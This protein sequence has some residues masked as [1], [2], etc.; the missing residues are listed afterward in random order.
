[1][2]I[3]PFTKHSLGNSNETLPA[4]ARMRSEVERLFDR[5]LQSP[6]AE[7]N[8][9]LSSSFAW[10]P[11]VDIAENDAELTIRAE[12]PGIDPGDVNVSISDNLLTISGEKREE[13]EEK[14]E[15][16]YHCERRF[17]SFTRSIEL[18]TSVDTGKILAEQENGVLTIHAPKLASAKPRHIEVKQSAGR[19]SSQRVP[20]STH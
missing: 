12:L 4:I 11:T 8:E 15:K 3:V 13:K 2:R 18:P 7:F 16:Y 14:G 17:G 20:V 1:M 10:A 19:K 6:W 9:P 5:F